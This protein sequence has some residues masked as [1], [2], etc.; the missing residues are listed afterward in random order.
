MT[1]IRSAIYDDGDIY[2]RKCERHMARLVHGVLTAGG[3]QL[4][5]RVKYFCAT[6]GTP[7]FYAEAQPE[8]TPMPEGAIQII[9]ALGKDYSESWLYQKEL[10]KRK[11]IESK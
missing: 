5:G 3:I 9:N 10:K 11:A 4:Y 1:E 8:D 2:C 7:Y 6:C